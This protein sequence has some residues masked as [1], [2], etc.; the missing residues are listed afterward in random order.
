MSTFSPWHILAVIAFL[1]VAIIFA[2]AAVLFL[3]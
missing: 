1:G 2:P 3:P